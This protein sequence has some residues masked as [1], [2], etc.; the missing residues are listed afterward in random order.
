[1]AHQEA[2]IR[3]AGLTKSRVRTRIDLCIRS[4]AGLRAHIVPRRAR[5]GPG[6]CNEFLINRASAGSTSDCFLFL[7]SSTHTLLF[8]DSPPSFHFVH[9]SHSHTHTLSLRHSNSC[10]HGCG[11][12]RYV[13]LSW[14]PSSTGRIEARPWI[15]TCRLHF[16]NN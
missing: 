4:T 6:I 10:A 14:T 3:E 2:D 9:L 12:R 11:L 13:L 1:M 8:T 7:S 5:E 16:P 15:C